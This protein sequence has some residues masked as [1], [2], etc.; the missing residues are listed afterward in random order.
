[1]HEQSLVRALFRQVSELQQARNAC[2]VHVVRVSVGQFSGV[3]PELLQSAFDELIG[4]SHLAGAKLEL[5]IVPL[6]AR[7][8]ACSHEFAVPNFQFRC[9]RC[10]DRRVDILRGEGLVLESVTLEESDD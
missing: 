9:P 3:E 5:V 8:R 1:M 10:R 2:G 6:E 7:C 4:D